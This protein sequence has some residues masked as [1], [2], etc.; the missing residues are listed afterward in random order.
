MRYGR[1]RY[2]ESRYGGGRAHD[3]PSVTVTSPT[4]SQIFTT[5]PTFTVGWTYAQAQGD[6]QGQFRIEVLDATLT[7]TYYDSGFLTGTDGTIDIDAVA[8]GIPTD[9]SSGSLKVRVTVIS[10]LGAPYTT[11]SAAVAFAL[12][13]GA[14]TPV[15]V[16]PADG[17][18]V[19]TAASSISVTWTGSPDS[20][21][22]LITQVRLRL[23][24]ADSG[25]L[26]ADTGFLPWV[27]GP[28]VIPYGLTS[29]S[30]YKIG[31]T[32]QNVDGVTSSEVYASFWYTP[33]AD[34]TASPL[35][36]VGTIYEVG[37]NGVGYMLFDGNTDVGQD[38]RSE[39]LRRTRD[40]KDLNPPRLATSQTP[41]NESIDRYS[42][43]GA[44]DYRGGTGQLLADRVTSDDSTFYDSDG[45]DPFTTPH[46]FSL[47]KQTTQSLASAY[48]ALRAVVANDVAYLQ[49]AASQLTHQAD[50]GAAGSAV[51]ITTD[52]ST[53]V[54]IAD[55]ASDGQYWYAA[56]G[57]HGVL[58]GQLTDPAAVW[59]SVAAQV[60]RWA[61]QRL[62][63]AYASTGSTPNV[64]STLTNGGAEEV[65]GGRLILDAGWTI[66][67]ITGGGGFVW[68]TAYSANKGV[69]Y[70][71]DLTSST[72]SVAWE[73]PNG[74]IPMAVKWYQGEVF[75]R[76]KKALTSTPT[77]MALIYQATIQ[78][79]NLTPLL[80]CQLTNGSTPGAGVFGANDRFVF[81]NW[82]DHG[83]GHAGLGA[84]DLSSGGY[85]RWIK[86]PTSATPGIRSI[87]E[88]R[89]RL[90]FTVDGSGLYCEHATNYVLSGNLKAS[91]HDGAS[92]V[93][94]IW[95]RVMMQFLPLPNGSE[96]D[97]AATYD[98]GNSYATVTN[99]SA[100]TS[101][102]VT[103]TVEL[104]ERSTSAGTQITLKPNQGT[105]TL[106]PV[107]TV[108]QLQCHPV[109]KADITL[110]LPIDCGDII[111]DL[112]SRALPENG[113]GA[114]T[115]RARL[116]ENLQSQ[117]VLVQDID[118][119]DTSI[120]E[121]FEVQEVRRI[122]IPAVIKEKQ[123]GVARV[124][125]VALITLI[126]S[127]R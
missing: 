32:L 25:F 74:Q 16:T 41:F 110:Q 39:L 101:G 19:L 44:S 121:V 109:D 73:L 46:Q 3:L 36:T 54:T 97:L 104:D 56:T 31:L 90:F 61:G 7:T 17:S 99:W 94:K 126:R 95:D 117:R 52:G 58:R 2:G 65:P 86:G 124:K 49:T 78:S 48:T 13:F 120:T 85:S 123:P 57:S 6:P 71:W 81:F 4:A 24:A 103:S 62:C 43:Y 122:P 115:Q 96:I 55:L 116:L 14:I 27:S 40:V 92:G 118:W 12:Q 9:G 22:N 38:I 125:E 29:G 47:L 68:F 66:T 15:I 23:L 100:K 26:Y 63:V 30:H 28:S 112:N 93:T 80:L 20:R 76:A 102:Q 105:P 83:D 98:G 72:P 50:P 59:S 18:V 119:H 1:S 35:A 10:S 21:G 69:V 51:N 70:K 108:W 111:S 8:Q 77:D 106:S 5:G 84:I 64:F 37:I 88:W 89:N 60:A 114:G 79:G 113:D 75:V 33:N 82:G 67:D 45:I 34:I 11:V 127:F 107:V 87:F 42:F 53:A 91:I